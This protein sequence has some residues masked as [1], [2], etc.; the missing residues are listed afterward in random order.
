MPSPP[1]SPLKRR[2]TAP[3]PFPGLLRP[4]SKDL[5]LTPPERTIVCGDPKTKKRAMQSPRRE[6][7]VEMAPEEVEPWYANPWMW[8]T[9]LWG[10]F[11][12]FLG[13]IFGLL[14]ANAN[15]SAKRD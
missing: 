2:T 9:C 11:T 6:R 8:F 12:F 15:F 1:P 4:T 14:A 3:I 13:G 10:L 5:Q 7:V